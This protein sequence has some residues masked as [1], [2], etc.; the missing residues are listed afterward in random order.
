MKKAIFLCLFSATLL[1][2]C[3]NFDRDTFNTLSASNAVLKTA[4]ADY[5]SGKIPH[6]SC[7][8]KI[9]TDAKVVQL[10][11]ETAFLDYY[12]IEQAKG[13]TTATQAVVVTDLTALVPVIAQVKSLYSN[14][15]CGA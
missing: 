10:T 6:N 15:N 14:P 1:I 7:D 2:G 5:E 8:F 12:Q 3:T 4:Q 13:N 11:A 9:I